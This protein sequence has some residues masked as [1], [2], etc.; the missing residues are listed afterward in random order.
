[1]SMAENYYLVRAAVL[2]AE[3]AGALGQPAD[4]AALTALAAAVSSA[5]VAALF[6]TRH[7][8]WDNGN[9]NAQAMA[10]AVAL[11]GAATAGANSSIIAALVSDLAAH[12]G[13]PNGG[14]AST[15]W[16]FAGLDA[17][18]R[19]DL[20]LSLATIPTAPGWAYMVSR[21]AE[22]GSALNRLTRLVLRL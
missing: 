17:A 8:A 12:G 21:R 4:A 11:G 22:G 16:T 10:L 9:A 5:M 14:V 13:H 19:A 6:D 3:I 1:M 7:G 2:A 15:R 20:A 18:G